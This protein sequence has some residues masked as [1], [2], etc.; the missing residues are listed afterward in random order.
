MLSICTFL[1]FFVARPPVSSRKM[2]VRM[3]HRSIVS[4]QNG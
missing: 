2:S 4:C 3:L 1:F